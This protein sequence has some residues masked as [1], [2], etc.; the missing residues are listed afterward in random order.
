VIISLW[1]SFY[2]VGAE[3]GYFFAP[4][5]IK[6]VFFCLKSYKF[7]RKVEAKI[8]AVVFLVVVFM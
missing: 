7:P 6:W 5:G 2:F 1:G 3:N 4:E 8:D